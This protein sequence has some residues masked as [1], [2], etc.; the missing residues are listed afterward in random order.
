MMIV[1]SVSRA[2]AWETL[3]AGPIRR[4]S[5]VAFSQSV[6]GTRGVLY[7]LRSDCTLQPMLLRACIMNNQHIVHFSPCTLVSRCYNT[8]V[9]V[10]CTV[11]SVQ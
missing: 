3:I 9:S 1:S 2:G 8:C 5:S 11:R 7:L 6:H 10:H 4:L